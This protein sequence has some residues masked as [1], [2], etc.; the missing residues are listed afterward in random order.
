MEYKIVPDEDRLLVVHEDAF[1]LFMECT[2]NLGEG[3]LRISSLE[4]DDCARY[5]NGVFH[6]PAVLLLSAGM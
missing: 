1:G 2:S 3:E 5:I 6:C 4:V